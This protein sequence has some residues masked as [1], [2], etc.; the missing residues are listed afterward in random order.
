MPLNILKKSIYLFLTFFFAKNSFALDSL[1]YSGRLVQTNGAPVTGTVTIKADLAYTNNLGSALCSQT[2][3]GVLLTK[4][5]FHLKLNFN[6]SASGMSLTQVLSQ[7]PAN[8]SV[9][10][11]ITDIS[12]AK[13][14]SYQAIHAMPFANVASQ[15]VQ[16][17]AGDGE[18]LKWDNTAKEWK[19]GGVTGASGGTVTSVSANGPLSVATPTSTPSISIAQANGT[20]SGYLSSADWNTFNSKE[21]TLAGGTVSQFYRGDKTWQTLETSAVSENVNLYFTNARALGVPLTGFVTAAGAI[22]AADTTLQ[23]FGKAQGQINAINTAAS[24]YLIKNSTDSVTGV[25]NVG[26]TGLLQLAY[27]PVGMNDAVNK[28]YVDTKLN[29]TGGTL[30]GVLTV[31][32]DLKL[33]GGSNHVTVKGHATSANYNLVLP[34]TAGTA[35]YVL[36][37]DGSGNTTWSSPAVGS[38]TITDG[39]IVDADVN[40][41]AAIAQTKIANLTT[42]LAGKVSTTL[43]SGNIFVGNGSNVA[44][45][46]VVSGD[47]VLSNAGVLTLANTAVTAG[48]Y[49]SITVDGK[50]RVTAGTNPVVVTAVSV[51]APITNTGTAAV[52]LIGMPVATGAADGYLSS[53]NFTTFNNKQNAI[54]AATDI[55]SG[56]ITT[57]KQNALNVNPF[58][59]A[60]G[61]TGELRFYE[62]TAGGTNYTGFKAPNALVADVIYTLPTADG[63]SGQVLSTNSSGVLSWTSIPSAMAPNGSAGGGL[64]GSY[65]NPTIASGLD[66]VK[67]S[68]GSV[69]NAEFDFLDGVTSSIQTQLNGKQ[70]IDTGLTNFAAFNTNGILVQT[71]NDTYFGRSIAGVANRTTVTNG[72]GVSGNPTINID[73]GLLPSPAGSGQWLKSTGANTSAWTTLAS[74]DI[75]GALGFTPVNKAG[76]TIATGTIAFNAIGTLSL[77]YT[78][79]N[80]T[81]ATSKSYVD[82]AVATAQ[83]QWTYSGGHVY[84][85][86]GNVGIGTNSPQQLLHLGGAASSSLVQFT[87]TTTGNTGSDGSYAGISSSG[88]MYVWNQEN[89]PLLFG[90]NNG[91]R[92]RIDSAGNVGIGT[93]SPLFS[94]TV[95]NNQASATTWAAVTNNIASGATGYLFGNDGANWGV[96]TMNSSGNTSYGGGNSL[97]IINQYN[98]PIT[99]A[100]AGSERVRITGAGNVGI[101]TTTP[102]A[103][104]DIYGNGS[105]ATVATTGAT[106]STTN[107]R[108]GRGAVG[109]N[110]GMLDSGTGYIQNRYLNDNAQNYPLVINP[111]GGNVGISTTTPTN[112]LNV[113]N[114]AAFNPAANV[115]SAI[116]VGPPGGVSYGGGVL[117]KDGTNYAGMWTNGNGA[118]LV[119]ASGGTTGGFAATNQVTITSGNIAAP[120]CV[121]YNGGTSG[122]CLS[123][124]RLK[125][126]IKRFDLGLNKIIKIKPVSYKYNGLGEKVADTNDRLGVIAQDVEKVAPELVERRMVYLHEGDKDKTEV[127]AVNYN[128]FTYMLIN[129]V[130]ELYGKWNSDHDQIENQKREIASLK[131]ENEE[132]KKRMDRLEK[133]L[134]KK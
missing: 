44:T 127:K 46:V 87:N 20:T 11:R 91:E 32:D 117:M 92:M 126:D 52:P 49:S 23:A 6:C 39:T 41:S 40:A 113:M 83:N 24:N 80:A 104:L 18:F 50:G 121:Y 13:A 115:L 134:N 71:A 9:A 56:S 15:L 114:F 30:S 122:T 107:A 61:N 35:G 118:S 98:A 68:A 100:T 2:L 105:G 58:G 73:T 72:D 95:T 27:V 110:I 76:D 94:L 10:I 17:G 125:K 26:T 111:N 81:D 19:P 123:D 21:G 70:A 116:M 84:R 112:A 124:R 54:T 12:N 131:S 4:G 38:S 75:T 78:P 31:D 129:S 47:A 62:L 63:S 59:A 3:P 85:S 55:I 132:L 37:T 25:V 79:T 74:A 93:T 1:S 89:L 109:I 42:D 86:S 106:D 88:N 64:A 33:K 99:L 66:A 43:T 51:S 101:G 16:M 45:G 14:Y 34:Q 82:N 8:E 108:F 119:L 48:T 60:A 77:A 128:S 28:S 120:G 133:N 97:N 36:S 65:P 29:L 22:V 7:T 103:K 90:T 5:V 102:Q 57:N 130:K 69:S 96:L 67:L 53:A